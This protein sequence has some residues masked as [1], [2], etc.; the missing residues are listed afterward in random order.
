[1]IVRLPMRGPTANGP[2]EKG[3]VMCCSAQ[4]IQ[5]HSVGQPATGASYGRIQKAPS[6]LQLA[7]CVTLGLFFAG[8]VVPSFLR[9]GMA[10]N[11]ALAVGSLRALTIGRVTRLF[12]IGRAS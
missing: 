2:V 9:S 8:I 11:H 3:G 10:T 5:N 4:R 7:G 1:M 6:V 12:K